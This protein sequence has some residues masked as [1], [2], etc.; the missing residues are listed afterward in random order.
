M[1]H[2]AKNAE[3]THVAAQKQQHSKHSTAAYQ[4]Q[5]ALNNI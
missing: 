5:E 2:L 1:A 3:N 4:P